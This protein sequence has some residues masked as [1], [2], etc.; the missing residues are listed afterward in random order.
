MRCSI[1]PAEG[2][3]DRFGSI[4]LCVMQFMPTTSDVARV[5]SGSA[6]G[7]VTLCA[8]RVCAGGACGTGGAGLFSQ[9]QLVVTGFSESVY[10][11]MVVN[12]NEVGIAKQA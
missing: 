12:E 8:V 7:C 2:D 9:D 10:L 4:G 11:V 5:L 6:A 3:F 1:S